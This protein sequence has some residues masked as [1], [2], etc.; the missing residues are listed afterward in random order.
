MADLV[1]IPAN[2]KKGYKLVS[3]DD[4]RAQTPVTRE[5]IAKMKRGDVLEYLEA[6]GVSEADCE[7]KRLPEIRALLSRVMFMEA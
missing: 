3:A 4:P 7:G 6:H 1:R 5:A 2:T